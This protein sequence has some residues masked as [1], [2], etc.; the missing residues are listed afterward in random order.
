MLL[1]PLDLDFN[2]S[3]GLTPF[4]ECQFHFFI[5][6]FISDLLVLREEPKFFNFLLLGDIISWVIVVKIGPAFETVLILEDNGLFVI[7]IELLEWKA[8]S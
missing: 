7:G 4:F 5:T 2:P 8:V 1:F 6:P 3:A